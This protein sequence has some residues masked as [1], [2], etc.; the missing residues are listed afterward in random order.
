MYFEKSIIYSTINDPFIYKYYYYIII[1]FPLNQYLKKAYTY[2][3]II[4]FSFFIK[5]SLL[6]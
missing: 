6:L 5:N 2:Y 1:F 4:L 3:Q